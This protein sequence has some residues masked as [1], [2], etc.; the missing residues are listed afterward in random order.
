MKSHFFFFILLLI[1][2]L[3]NSQISNPYSEQYLP[4]EN[5]LG[6]EE[7]NNSDYSIARNNFEDLSYTFDTI[8]RNYYDGLS[9]AGL[10][11]SI[12]VGNEQWSGAAGISSIG[13]SL[14]TNMSMAMGSISKSI[15]ASTILKL[16]EEGVLK[17]SDELNKWIDTYPNIDSTITIRQLLNHSS[18]IY[19][20]TDNL[21]LITEVNT[22]S[23]SI[24]QPKDI[25]NNYIKEPYFK[26][27]KDFHYSNTNYLLIG[28]IIEAATGKKYHEIVREKVLQ[29]A[30]LDSIYLKPFEENPQYLAHLWTS[31]VPGSSSI[32][33]ISLGYKLDALFSVA[34]AAGAYTSKTSDVAL[35]MKKLSK[36]EILSANSQ[37]ELLDGLPRGSD[38]Y[39]GLGIV[40]FEDENS[41]NINAIGHNGNIGYTSTAF[42]FPEYDI[43]IAVQC[44]D[45]SIPQNSLENLL[46]KFLFEYIGTLN[47][48][49]SIDDRNNITIFPNPVDDILRINILDNTEKT[50]NISVFNMIGKKVLMVS[51]SNSDLDVSGLEPGIYYLSIEGKNT[52]RF[53]KK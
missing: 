51:G 6:I 40:Y 7:L 20:M 10:S 41:G 16:E 30:G 21:V 26:K 5:N 24:W 2:F 32:D 18:G 19:S 38:S 47:A 36:G 28:M 15:A 52:V 35:W 29:P 13:D 49:T 48:T 45:T 53:I 25:L 42:Y 23:D 22:H 12:I 14:T 11:A 17:L 46:L 37:N 34:W 1:P 39:Y 31:P 43:S 3:S 4:F 8:L 50:K 33:V 27:G 44:N 9:I